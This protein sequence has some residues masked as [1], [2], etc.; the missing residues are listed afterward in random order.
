M[1]EAIDIPASGNSGVSLAHIR[2]EVQEPFDGTFPVYRV[3]GSVNPGAKTNL[4]QA[5]AF[6]LT[7]T[8][9][10]AGWIT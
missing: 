4:W 10:P 6:L 1:W 2:V 3:A 7:A 9:T 8:K 5:K